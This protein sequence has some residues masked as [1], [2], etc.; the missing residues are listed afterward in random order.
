M[1]PPAACVM[2]PAALVIS[3]SP[4]ALSFATSN[5]VTVRPDRSMREAAP[6][7]TLS[8]A[9]STKR[10]EGSTMLPSSPT[11]FPLSS[12]VAPSAS[13]VPGATPSGTATVMSPPAVI[14]I[15]EAAC[16]VSTGATTARLP[17]S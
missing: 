10:P 12:S 13:L 7:V 5:S 3:S 1:R 2:W 16:P 15:V 4:P 9:A 11:R 8:V 6:S 14:R 17:P